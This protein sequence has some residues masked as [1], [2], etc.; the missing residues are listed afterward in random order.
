MNHAKLKALALPALAAAALG[1]CSHMPMHHPKVLEQ[2]ACND[3]TVSLYFEPGSDAVAGI[4]R[5][6]I[7]ETAK[8]L[9]G[10]P[11]RELNLV[12]LAD[13]GGTPEANLEISKRRAEHV[14]D[15]F[16]ASGLPVERFT[17]SASGEEGAVR[18][19]GV[20][21]PVRRRVNVTVVMQRP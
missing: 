14:R 19:S 5:R 15:A 9:K 2:S 21:E 6:I 3:T 17:L 10:C 13:A 8:R 11:V 16:I 18:P 4:G 12:G 7:A 1:G 20:V